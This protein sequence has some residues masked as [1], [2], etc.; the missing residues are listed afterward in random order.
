MMVQDTKWTGDRNSGYLMCT[1]TVY[2]VVYIVRCT[3]PFTGCKQVYVST[4]QCTG[5]SL[6][7]QPAP[8][9]SKLESI[10][11]LAERTNFQDGVKYKN[12]VLLNT[13]LKWRCGKTRARGG[14]DGG[15][16]IG[17][18]SADNSAGQKTKRLLQFLDELLRGLGQN[19]DM[20]YF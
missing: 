11:T 1:F 3:V 4:D 17:D 16:I 12:V 5:C 8:G 13:I 20:S 7:K 9:S 18:F 6:E 14:N 19:M 10:K 15:L 2:N